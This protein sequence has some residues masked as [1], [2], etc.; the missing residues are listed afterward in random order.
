MTLQRGRMQFLQPRRKIFNIRSKKIAQCTKM[1]KNHSIIQ[2]K[3]FDVF[4]W[5][6]R[7]QFSQHRRKIFDEG[8]KNYLPR[9]QKEKW[10]NTFFWK[11]LFE[12]MY[13]WARRKQFSIL[14][15]Q[16]FDTMP[17]HS[18][19]SLKKVSYHLFFE[20]IIIRKYVFLDT[21]KAVVTMPPKSFQR[22]GET[23]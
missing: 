12:K 14:R 9:S 23:Y 5:A 17:K 2:K 7:K 18:T 13:V 16:S 21:L 6:Q 22:G 20:K 15:R 8:P 4:L 19:Q 10:N 1:I 11:Y 3:I